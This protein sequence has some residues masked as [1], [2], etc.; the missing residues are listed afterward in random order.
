MSCAVEEKEECETSSA[1]ADG[2][3]FFIGVDVGGS[4][5]CGVLVD[6]RQ[7]GRIKVADQLEIPARPGVDMVVDDIVEV[8]STLSQR[9]EAPI[10]GVGIGIPGR[11][12]PAD[13]IVEDVAN[14]DIDR[15]ELAGEIHRRTSLPV[16]VEN[17]VNAAAVGAYHMLCE[18]NRPAESEGEDVVAFLNLG[19]G[20][21]AGILRGGVPDHGFSNAVGEVGHI[22][23]EPHGWNCTCGQKGC[24]E[25]AAGGHSIARM[26]PYADPPMPDIISCVRDESSPRHD[27]AVRCLAVIVSAI[28]DALDILVMT[29]DPRIVVIGGGTTKV[30]SPLLDEIKR[31]LRRREKESAF[32][33]SLNMCDRLELAPRDLPLGALGAA[34]VGMELEP[35]A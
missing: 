14:L 9:N 34:L 24:L 33:A 30:G 15:L 28:A 35:V 19:T 27:A 18:A 32:V 3:S 4:K 21:A 11:V 5:I 6:A 2:A 26:W 8:I 10:A 20:V 16:R 25:T 12:N 13:G 29:I 31:E 17:D 1:H 23:V 7:G 22:P